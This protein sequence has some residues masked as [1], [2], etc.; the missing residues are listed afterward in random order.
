MVHGT[1]DELGIQQELLTE[2][3]KSHARMKHARAYMLAK[4]GVETIS[5]LYKLNKGKPE[6]DVHLDHGHHVPAGAS[7]GEVR[8]EAKDG[9]GVPSGA[10]E[11]GNGEVIEGA[12][13][14][15]NEPSG[16]HGANDG[17]APEVEMDEATVQPGSEDAGSE[18]ADMSAY[19]KKR[20]ANAERQR[21]FKAAKAKARNHQKAEKE[22]ALKAMMGEEKYAKLLRQR[23]ATAARVRAHRSK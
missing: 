18:D 15:E 2:K 12:T 8:V 20:A 1:N 13:A 17:E 4:Y 23:E 14:G 5:D 22:L 11:A 7:D 10:H 16:A 6:E 3:Q 21:K 19:D 9:E